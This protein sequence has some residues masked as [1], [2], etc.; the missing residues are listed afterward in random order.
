MKIS[1]RSATRGSAGFGRASA[2][3]WVKLHLCLPPYV[4]FLT[5]VFTA[6]KQGLHD[7]AAGTLVVTKRA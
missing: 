4:W 3:H 2:R 1:N 5:I 7:I 6:R